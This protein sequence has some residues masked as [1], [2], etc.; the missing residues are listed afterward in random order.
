MIEHIE[1]K[2]GCTYV[3]QVR[4]VWEVILSTVAKKFVYRLV[5]ESYRSGRIVVYYKTFAN[6]DKAL[7]F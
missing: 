5:S 3:Y 2:V 1:C 7:F 6:I 4:D